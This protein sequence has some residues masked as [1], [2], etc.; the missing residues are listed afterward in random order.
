MDNLLTVNTSSELNYID[1]Y[2]MSV[3]DYEYDYGDVNDYHDKRYIVTVILSTLITL[4]GFSLLMVILKNADVRKSPSSWLVINVLLAILL[5]G[6][7]Y[8]PMEAHNIPDFTSGEFGCHFIHIVQTFSHLH[9]QLSLL[10]VFIDRFVYFVGPTKYSDIMTPRVVTILICLSIL[11]HLVLSVVAI[12]ATTYVTLATVGFQYTLTVCYLSFRSPGAEYAM[13]S[14]IYHVPLLLNLL[15]G[16]ISIITSFGMCCCG[17]MTNDKE[18]SMRKQAIGLIC[19][20]LILD[21]GFTLPS[22]S[23]FLSHYHFDHETWLVYRSLSTSFFFVVNFPMMF[24]IPEIR[25]ALTS[26]CTSEK[27]GEKTPLV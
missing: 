14:L 2:N 19:V 8:L 24:L 3:Y 11:F 10:L 15:V 6:L 16:T 22:M 25:S 23:F 21:L 9:I 4:T 18:G 12:Y 1:H 17:K 7:I 5:Q 26:C 13:I 20:T 27:K